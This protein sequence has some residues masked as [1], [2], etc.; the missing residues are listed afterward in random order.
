[1]VWYNVEWSSEEDWWIMREMKKFKSI[2]D[3]TFG[4]RNA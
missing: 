3:M 2:R 1:M 4:E